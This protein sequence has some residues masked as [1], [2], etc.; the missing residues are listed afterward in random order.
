MHFFSPRGR[1]LAG[2]QNM[3]YVNLTLTSCWNGCLYYAL[4]SVWLSN[5]YPNN[6]RLYNAIFCFLIILNV[7]FSCMIWS[8]LAQFGVVVNHSV[9]DYDYLQRKHRRVN[10]KKK[11]GKRGYSYEYH[12]QIPVLY[13][14]VLQT[15]IQWVL[16]ITRSSVFM[17]N[18]LALP[19]TRYI[20]MSDLGRWNLVVYI[21]FQ[22]GCAILPTI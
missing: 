11:F 20:N 17:S 5:S 4:K 6:R 15:L 9:E 14:L 13:S 18:P 10:R 19:S 21:I 2:Q 22:E 8:Y 16:Y 1:L 3:D 7:G 12:T